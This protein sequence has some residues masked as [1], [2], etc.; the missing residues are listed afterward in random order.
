[1][2]LPASRAEP[3]VEYVA[4]SLVVGVFFPGVAVGIAYPTLPQLE[5]V[6]GLSPAIVGAI[7]STT[8]AVRLL[9]NAPAGS[10]FDRV[11]TRRPLLAGFLALG[12]APFGYAIGLTPGVLPVAP[13]V[14]FLLSRAVAGVG[15]ALIVVGGYATITA[16][17]TAENRGR[18]LGYMLGSYGLG[19]PVGML[20][21]GVVADRFGFREAFLLAGVLGVLAVLLVYVLVPDRS[22]AVER[23][24]GLR[25][26]PGLL[27]AD[28]RLVA[29]GTTKGVLRFLS[30]AFLTTVVLF[31]TELGLSFGALGGVGVGG[32]VLALSS[33]GAAGANLAAGRVSDALER[34][35]LVV[36]P[37]LAVLAGGF[38]LV[39]AVPTL[40]GVLAGALAAGVGGGAASPVLYAALGDI[41][42]STDVGKLGGA[43]NV[44]GDVGAIAGPVVALP[45]ADSFG[46]D[47]L[48]LGCGGLGVLAAVVVATALH[49]ANPVSPSTT[50]E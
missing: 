11:G 6:L 41:S 24:A 34:R 1:M 46:F 29:L 37:S 38:A 17:T 16:V 48:Y 19:F 43:F 21:G 22:A 8:G 40:S 45:A 23:P 33:V 7:I 30:A 25:K 31:A 32:V 27:R 10:L 50:T 20:A 28:R 18:W 5:V 9:C 26:L 39:A 12:V 42:P 4:G 14:V 36:V 15:T 44:F 35:L 13:T 3:G 49:S 2:Q 47:A